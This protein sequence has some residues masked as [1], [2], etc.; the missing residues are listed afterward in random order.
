MSLSCGY[1]KITLRNIFFAYPSDANGVIDGDQCRGEEFVAT[2][3]NEVDSFISVESCWSVFLAYRLSQV[4]GFHLE[5]LRLIPAN[6]QLT[7]SESGARLATGEERM[8]TNF[9]ISPSDYGL[10][11]VKTKLTGEDLDSGGYQIISKWVSD[12]D[13]N[14]IQYLSSRENIPATSG[15][16]GGVQVAN[17]ADAPPQQIQSGPPSGAPGLS[18]NLGREATATQTKSSGKFCSLQ[19]GREASGRGTAILILIFGIL[20]SLLHFTFRRSINKADL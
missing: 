11:A 3:I 2:Q 4:S 12:S 5:S 16:C 14:V 9:G 15:G 20:L 10:V 6:S 17:G 7:R 18:S 1:G 19:I 8:P 13:S